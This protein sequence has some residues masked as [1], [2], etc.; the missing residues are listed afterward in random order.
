MLRK[1]I[2][3]ESCNY[4]KISPFIRQQRRRKKEEKEQR[5]SKKFPVLPVVKESLKC[6]D[7]NAKER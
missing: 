7:Y 6:S 3:L 4:V 1:L 5:E 2:L